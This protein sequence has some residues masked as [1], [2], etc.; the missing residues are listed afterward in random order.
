MADLDVQ[1]KKKSKSGLPWIL[2]GLG[3]LALI[4][5]LLRGCNDDN[6]ADSI[7]AAPDS[8][9][10][11]NNMAQ[12]GDAST[13]AVA[14]WW[15]NVDMNAPAASFDEITNKDISVRG[16][17]KYGIYGIGESIL[18]DEGK[19]S[20][21][22][23]AEANLK[24]IVASV[25]KRYQG[26]NIRIYGYTD[27]VG[28]AGYNKELAEQR[29]E[30]VKNWLSKSGIPTA[31]LTTHPVGE[32]QP[33]ASNDSQEGRRQN[34]RV[35]IVAGASGNSAGSG[36]TGGVPHGDTTRGPGSKA[37]DSTASRH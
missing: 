37:G 31:N 9:A 8:S 29:T 5:F 23:Q 36:S 35:E 13:N 22:P 30:A 4:I 18:F 12:A 2:L 34:R 19:S 24:Q 20:I 21:K 25:N 28:S 14:D 6:N 17:E 16:N 1:P 3:V 27:A 32:A 11:N 10:N 26:G 15:D 33:R 7:G